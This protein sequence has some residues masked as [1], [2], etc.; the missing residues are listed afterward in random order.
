MD[1]EDDFFR[2]AS[3]YPYEP[4]EVQLRLPAE[5]LA[6]TLRLLGRVS[7]RESGLFWYGPRDN[8][9]NGT[10]AY[11]VAPRQRMT[12]GN[13]SIAPQDLASVVH[14][15]LDGWKPLAQIHSHPG[16][17]VEHSQ[18]D[19]R[20]VSSTRVLSV[21]FPSYGRSSEKSFPSGVGIH[22]W[23]RDYWHLLDLADAQRRVVLID[24]TVRM[25]DFR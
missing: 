2:P 17:R 1:V 13:Y 21:V 18:Y 5:G 6:A 3:R 20:M 19:D 4:V 8:K 22:E 11:V 10:V 9:G 25:E 16:A 24:G 14:G 7:R 15:L 12:W 23:Q